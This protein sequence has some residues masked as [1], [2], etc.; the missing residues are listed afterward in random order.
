MK[1]YRVTGESVTV[2]KDYG[3]V[4]TPQGEVFYDHGDTTYAKGKVLTEEDVSQGQRDAV[5]NGDPWT[6]RLLEEISQSEYEQG[7]EAEKEAPR[8]T[9]PRGLQGT[10]AGGE[11]VDGL[12]AGSGAD[13]MAAP[14]TTIPPI[15]QGPE[16]GLPVPQDDEDS[17]VVTPGPDTE[18]T[19]VSA[20]VQRMQEEEDA[21]RR[22]Q[23]AG[24]PA[25]AS[26]PT[27]SDVL[28][29]KVPE[30]QA[31][32]DEHPEEAEAIRQR[33]AQGEGRKG[34]VEYEPKRDGEE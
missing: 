7:L 15:G 30:V 12:L 5:E 21:V 29:G 13:P 20:E 19:D 2:S 1:Y 28:D 10:G 18:M 8:G 16:A 22:A 6:S 27:S 34:I 9:I 14:Q 33:E 3:S 17:G 4:E 26:E 24:T 32:M 11:S 31:Y 25:A 23:F